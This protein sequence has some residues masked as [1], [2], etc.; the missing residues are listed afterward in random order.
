VPV[1]FIYFNS[2]PPNLVVIERILICRIMIKDN[3]LLQ[4]VK[5]FFT[6]WSDDFSEVNTEFF[7]V[8]FSLI[9]SAGLFYMLIHFVIP[10]KENLIDNLSFDYV[11]PW[12]THTNTK[13]AIF[14]SYFGTGL[15]LLP[16]YIYMICL[17]AVR[18]YKTY[19]IFVFTVSVSGLLLGLVLK[20]LFQ[21][22]RPLHKMVGAGGYSFPSGHSLGGFIFCLLI[23]FLIW[24]L[25]TGRLNKYFLYFTSAVF[26]IL[27]GLSRVYL[28]VHYATDILGSFFVAAGWF[29]LIYILFIF[30]YGN[31]LHRAGERNAESEEMYESNYDMYN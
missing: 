18:G 10:E 2:G 25:K 9:M 22:P 13:L 12:I 8:L 11:R 20:E 29:A 27:I 24:K 26:G 23:I 3:K 16:A 14:V 7:I 15:F 19:A 4:N 28:H 1:S 5:D 30:V 31:D 21:R 6:S 17:L